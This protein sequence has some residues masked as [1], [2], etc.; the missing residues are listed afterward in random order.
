MAITLDPS[1]RKLLRQL[2]QEI[3]LTRDG[4]PYTAEFDVFHRRLCEE[5]RETFGKQEAWHALDT[6]LRRGG[7]K[8]MEQGTPAPELSHDEKQA[9]R[10]VMPG[11]VSRRGRWPYTHEFERACEDFNTLTGRS[12][13]IHA[14]WRAVCD[15]GKK[16]QG[17]ARQL[18]DDP[19]VSDSIA[20][21]TETRR[22]TSERRFFARNAKL[23]KLAKQEYGAT[24]QACGFDFKG[25][26]GAIGTGYIECHHLSP[27][28]ERSE[29]EWSKGIRTNLKE[30]TVL[31]ANCHRMVHRRRPALALEELQEAIRN[32]SQRR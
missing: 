21:Y 3:G 26:Y 13:P 22:L 11:P 18:V 14:V 17:P 19:V 12:L 20:E 31:C 25:K 4:L 10:N 6:E 24:C 16:G 27:L 2:Y 30:V 1:I 7:A 29:D 32:A 5:R 9:L 28:A 23:V 15:L 8:G